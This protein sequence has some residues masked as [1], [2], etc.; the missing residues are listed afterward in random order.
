[1]VATLLG[2]VLLD[3]AVHGGSST[4]FGNASQ[5]APSTPHGVYPCAGND[6][7]IAISVF[8]DDAWR[9]LGR[10]AGD[11]PWARDPR[12]ATHAGRLAHAAEA[13]APVAGRAGGPRPAAAMER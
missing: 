8:D 2:P 5:E 11:P 9:G 7:W 13:D 1:V 10:A 6:R 12:F 4:A 3:R